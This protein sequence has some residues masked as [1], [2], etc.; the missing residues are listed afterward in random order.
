MRDEDH[1]PK[2][3]R[4]YTRDIYSGF[5][6]VIFMNQKK[7]K[8]SRQI[9]QPEKKMSLKVHNEAYWFILYYYRNWTRFACMTPCSSDTG[10]AAAR[11]AN[12][13]GFP[14]FALSGLLELKNLE[15]AEAPGCRAAPGRQRSQ[16]TAGDKGSCESHVSWQSQGYRVVDLSAMEACIP[17]GPPRTQNRRYSRLVFPME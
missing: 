17:E 5:S 6:T 10:G 9:I 13:A 3:A 4:I 7:K 14:Q 15:Q 8:N 11:Y 1:L 12:T 16:G 2:K